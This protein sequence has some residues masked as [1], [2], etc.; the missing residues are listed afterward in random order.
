M[1]ISIV[2]AVHTLIG[3]GGDQLCFVGGSKWQVPR[4]H[5]VFVACQ[6]RIQSWPLIIQ[7]CAR[8]CV[9]HNAVVSTTYEKRV[10]SSQ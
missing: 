8:S 7:S 10:F 9:Y 6:K 5:T 2:W 4:G 3:T 1:N